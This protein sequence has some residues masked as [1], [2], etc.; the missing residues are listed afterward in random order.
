VIPPQIEF[1]FPGKPGRLVNTEYLPELSS[2]GAE[3]RRQEQ[4]RSDC[5]PAA[6]IP[7]PIEFCFPGKPG[8]LVN[9]EYLPELSLPGA[10]R[11]RSEQ[12][13]SDC[14]PAAD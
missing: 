5:D 13:R 2:S 6:D 12:E 4:E 14:D 7:V 1:C 8:R 9:M 10:K 3:R 11:R